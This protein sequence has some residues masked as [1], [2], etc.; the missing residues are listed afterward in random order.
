MIGFLFFC[1]ILVIAFGLSLILNLGFAKILDQQKLPN[2]LTLGLVPLLV[3]VTFAAYI[4]LFVY[5]NLYPW[6]Q[7]G[8]FYL[9]P[10]FHL[11]LVLV[12]GAAAKILK[13][14]SW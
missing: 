13:V 8:L 12:S 4:Y 5:E 9:Y 14:H 10:F 11:I 3:A 2:K 6:N 1:L 7:A